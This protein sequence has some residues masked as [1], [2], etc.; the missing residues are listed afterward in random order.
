MPVPDAGS[1]TGRFAAAATPVADA[2]N[3]S[4]RDAK[5]EAATACD[6][7]VRPPAAGSVRALVA[8]ASTGSSR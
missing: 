5:H 8:D 1:A 3:G 2:A 4:E 6:R 7:P